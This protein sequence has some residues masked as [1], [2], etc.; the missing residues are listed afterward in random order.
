MKTFGSFVFFL[1]LLS[2]I[3]SESE[4]EG[5]FGKNTYNC[6]CLRMSC[7]NLPSN[8]YVGACQ[9]K[10]FALKN[11]RYSFQTYTGLIAVQ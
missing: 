6:N 1:A 4:D 10:V 5:K 11:Y 9:R 3:A 8:W 7:K 2:P